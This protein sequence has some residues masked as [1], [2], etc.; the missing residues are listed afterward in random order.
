M[1]AKANWGRPKLPA[2]MIGVLEP[3]CV[4]R[5]EQQ[6]TPIAAATIALAKRR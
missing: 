3:W 6:N 1:D 2:G 5:Q 4:E